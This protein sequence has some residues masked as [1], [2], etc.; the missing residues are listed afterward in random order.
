MKF[1]SPQ[2]Y[3]AETVMAAH[4]IVAEKT[5]EGLF[6]LLAG[7]AV[8]TI[9]TVYALI[10]EFALRALSAVRAIAAV[11]K[12]MIV[13]AILI[14]VA[15]KSHVAIFAFFRVLAVR[16]VFILHALEADMRRFLPQELELFKKRHCSQNIPYLQRRLSSLAASMKPFCAV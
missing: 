1:F 3:T 13:E 12:S 9:M 14:L 2:P 4:T 8:I 10:A 15:R 16:T 5:V 6:A 11:E 7:I